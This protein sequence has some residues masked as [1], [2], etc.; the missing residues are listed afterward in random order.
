MYF[1]IFQTSASSIEDITDQE[2]EARTYHTLNLP[3]RSILK[4]NG[5]KLTPKK[6]MP[7]A[8][9]YSDIQGRVLVWVLTFYQC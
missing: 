6:G 9:S 5:G 8:S 7:K 2:R 3:L 4:N 1:V